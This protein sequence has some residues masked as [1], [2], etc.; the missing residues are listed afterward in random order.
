MNAAWG[1]II[2]ASV[3]LLTVVILRIWAARKYAKVRERI[4]NTDLQEVYDAILAAGN[5]SFIFLIMTLVWIANEAFAK[6]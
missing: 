3:F 4:E 6:I 2:L 1:Q 5:A